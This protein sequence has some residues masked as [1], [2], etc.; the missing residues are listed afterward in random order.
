MWVETDGDVLVN[1][2]PVDL[3]ASAA[4]LSLVNITS[5]ASADQTYNNVFLAGRQLALP[6]IDGTQA[7]VVYH[8]R[9]DGPDTDV[10]PC[11][12][13]YDAFSNQ[14]LTSV[15]R[16]VIR[17][18]GQG[19]VTP[20]GVSVSHTLSASG[21]MYCTLTTDPQYT[22]VYL[23]PIPF[24][25]NR[26]ETATLGETTYLFYVS[27]NTSGIDRA[28]AVG[29]PVLVSGRRGT[30]CITAASTRR[31]GVYGTGGQLVARPLCPAGQTVTVPL[32]PGLYVVAGKK[33]AVY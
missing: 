19:A 2:K 1:A 9:N 3:S 11:F 32:P 25:D 33:V 23:Q 6:Y 10:T 12:T 8:L 17:L 21:V 7:E 29:A 27:G 22:S 30:L 5:N 28:Q 14:E 24:L 13:V 18:P 31:V 20:L 15:T 4:M 26:N 16:D